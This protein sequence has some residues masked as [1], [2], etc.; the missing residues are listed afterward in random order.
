MKFQSKLPHI[1]THI[2]SEMSALANRHNAINLSQGFPNFEPSQ[3]L[4]SLVDVFLKKGTNQYAPMAGL[5]LLREQ[6]AQKIT[7]AYSIPVDPELEVTITAGATEAL[8]DTIAAFVYPGDEVII[9]EP[10][11]D[12]YRPAIEVMGGIPVVYKMP[13]PDFKINWQELQRLITPATRMICICTPNNPTGTV[14]TKTD[15]HALAGIV[16]G[17]G[18]F[19][20]SDEVYEHMVFD[21]ALHESPLKYPELRERTISVY[22]FGK[23][24]HITGWRIGYCVAS[25]AIT[26]EIRKVHQNN[27]FCASHPLQ[28]AIAAFMKNDAE[29]RGLPAFYQQKR[30]LLIEVTSGSLFK[31][32]PCPGSYFQLLDYSAL[33][34]DN[35]YLFCKTLITEYGVAAIPV[36]HLYS[37]KQD[38]KLIRLCFAK[39]DEVL[40]KAGALLSNIPAIK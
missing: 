14:L 2:F 21:G 19:I 13:F 29:Y 16:K 28:A 4:L 39:T 18:I 1:T 33:S 3:T 15:M 17:T 5:P 32:L 6:I 9:I 7:A 11:Y 23:T 25:P 8:F 38:D 37:D 35:D 30:D 22:S 26:R 36:S 12:S 10:C 31:A 20:L 40:I 27:N 34:I 24:F